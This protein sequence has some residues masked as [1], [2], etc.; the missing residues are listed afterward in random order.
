MTK[1]AVGLRSGHIAVFGTL[2]LVGALRRHLLA[3]PRIGGRIRG[4]LRL[5]MITGEAGGRQVGCCGFE[6]SGGRIGIIRLRSSA[7]APALPRQVRSAGRIRWQTGG[8][9][10]RL[11]KRPLRLFLCS[12][13]I[14][15][16]GGVG[17][18]PVLEFRGGSAGR[19]GTPRIAGRLVA[20]SLRRRGFRRGGLAV[21][22][23]ERFAQNREGSEVVV[24]VVE[25]VGYVVQGL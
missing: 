14:G 11:G 5:L 13:T 22:G 2:A 10:V 12:F 7:R 6:R 17:I 4:R 23:V 25:A 9:G 16:A 3:D 1:P 20:G 18:R 21:L 8:P 19:L 15:M 24:V